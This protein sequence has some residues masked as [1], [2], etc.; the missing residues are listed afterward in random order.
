MPLL[1]REGSASP[2][3]ERS[4][5]A[6]LCW[7]QCSDPQ[8]LLGSLSTTLGASSSAPSVC[9]RVAKE[10]V[11]LEVTFLLTLPSRAAMHLGSLPGCCS[12]ELF[13]HLIH[14]KLPSPAT[15]QLLSEPGGG[16]MAPAVPRGPGIHPHLGKGFTPE[17]P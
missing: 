3:V 5:P 9:L 2:G 11:A 14:I 10:M 7:M 8:D 13:Q 12:K 6:A 4:E 17:K 15:S 1:H 16:S